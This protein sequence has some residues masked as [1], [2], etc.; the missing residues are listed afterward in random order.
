[1][2]DRGQQHSLFL[3]RIYFNEDNLYKERPLSDYLLNEVEKSGLSGAT[4]FRGIMGFGVHHHVHT[5]SLLRLTESLPLILEIMDT[6]QKL[7]ELLQKLKP[8]LNEC[9]II[10][11]PVESINLDFL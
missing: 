8:A 10:K 1:M 3:V 6:E 9:T 4:V 2:E 5:T 7:L 11:I